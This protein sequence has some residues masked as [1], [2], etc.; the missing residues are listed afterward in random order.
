MRFEIGLVFHYERE[1]LFILEN[2]HS[3]KALIYY[4]AETYDPTVQ[5]VG[6]CLPTESKLLHFH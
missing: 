1:D 3:N 5:R 2:V 4:L 6:T